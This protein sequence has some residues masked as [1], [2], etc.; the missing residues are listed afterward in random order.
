MILAFC[1]IYVIMTLAGSDYAIL[2]NASF[3]MSLA[4]N[5]LCVFAYTEY[6]ILLLISGTVNIALNIQVMA[7]DPAHITYLIS[8]VYNFYC[9]IF[10]FI[11]LRKLYKE[12]QAL[13]CQ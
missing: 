7:Q 10:I 3:V 6:S 2:D 9:M 8:S 5:L 13:K 4:C 11:N 12:Q 1:L